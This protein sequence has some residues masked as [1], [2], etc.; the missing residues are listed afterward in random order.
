MDIKKMYTKDMFH[1]QI[2]ELIYNSNK[3]ESNELDQVYDT[4]VVSSEMYL[5]ISKNFMV[6]VLDKDR[7]LIDQFDDEISQDAEFLN[8]IKKIF[9]DAIIEFYNDK[10]LKND[11]FCLKEKIIRKAVKLRNLEEYGVIVGWEENNNDI[12]HVDFADEKEYHKVNISEL[13][14]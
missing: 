14:L 2:K 11:G 10:T 3:V 5:N 12:V 4:L 9:N 13:T 8:K 6:N 1:E 7:D